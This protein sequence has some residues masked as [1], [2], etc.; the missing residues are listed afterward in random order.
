MGDKRMLSKAITDNDNFLSLSSAA[1]AL[2]MHICLDCDDDGFSN[3]VS[4]AMF[5][6][7][8]SVG[9]LEQLIAKK[10]LIQFEDGVVVVKHWKMMNSIRGDRYIPTRFQH[11]LD[12]LFL[13]NNKSY[14]LAAEIVVTTNCQPSDNQVTTNGCQMVATSQV[15]LSKDKINQ[16]NHLPNVSK[17]IEGDEDESD[18]RVFIRNLLNDSELKFLKELIPDFIDREEVLDRVDM[19]LL[20]NKVEKPFAYVLTV[21]RSMGMV[22]G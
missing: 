11:H 21:A 17:R 6:A 10:Y 20:T 12:E 14:S 8:A 18:K 13:N 15:K 2:Y 5:K 3:Q 19:A 1:Q 16:S 22:H 7:H 4:L 9:D